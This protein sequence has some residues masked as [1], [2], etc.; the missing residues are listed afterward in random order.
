[1][2][3]GKVHYLRCNAIP[4]GGVTSTLVADRTISIAF[5]IN[6]F[7]DLAGNANA[8]SAAAFT[9]ISDHQAP[10][11][12]T[13]AA[14]G[15]T[16][17]TNG[18]FANADVTFTFTLSDPTSATALA[19]T[20]ITQAQFPYAITAPAD[21][22]A[23]P[24]GTSALGIMHTNSINC[25]GNAAR[26]TFTVGA[27]SDLAPTLLCPALTS[28]I[29]IADYGLAE[30]RV[31]EMDVAARTIL[32]AAAHATI[33]ADFG[34]G[35]T[36]QLIA[37]YEQGTLATAHADDT[38]ALTVTLP[39]N[40]TLPDPAATTASGADYYVGWT[41]E[42]E[43]PTGRGVV[44]NYD[45]TTKVATIGWESV[46]TDVGGTTTYTLTAP[47]TAAPLNTNLVIEAVNDNG[48]T[49][50]VVY[51]FRAGYAPTARTTDATGIANTGAAGA[52]AGG[53]DAGIHGVDSNANFAVECALMRPANR[54]IT[55]QIP[56]GQ[57]S[58]AA[59]NPNPASD[60]FL[61]TMDQTPPTVAVSIYEADGVTT[62]ADG[63]TTGSRAVIFKLVASEHIVSVD[64]ASGV[65]LNG[66]VVGD[67]TIGS[68][69]GEACTNKKFWGWKDTYYV[70]CDWTNGVTAKVS[71]AAD[72]AQDLAGNTCATCLAAVS[73][74][75]T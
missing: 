59:G 10:K 23:H 39:A 49:T 73:V 30:I 8:A 35:Q 5:A 64:T 48:A 65:G 25:N 40:P 7:Y 43:K 68:A 61:I 17:L 28:A 50:E 63:G 19:P 70:R 69:T 31:S 53:A 66:L 36:L 72:K 26:A 56:A 67:I 34:P 16:A 6:K 3:Q 9:V 46:V 41:I 27:G 22:T 37:R 58:D 33:D 1:M 4:E 44:T 18:S 74:T 24:D 52:V 11:I 45:G 55:V 32:V 51:L 38:T 57:F 21:W 20:A 12:V 2:P 42:T 13:T 14:A 75:F 71:I 62:I 29:T 47:C 60:P 15:A 54:D